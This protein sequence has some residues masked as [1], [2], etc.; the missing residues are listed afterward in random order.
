MSTSGLPIPPANNGALSSKSLLSVLACTNCAEIGGDLLRCSRCKRVC[1]CSKECQLKHWPDHKTWCSRNSDG[2]NVLELF[3]KA[4]A[5]PTF[6]N[7]LQAC[8]VLHFDLLRFPRTDKPFLAQIDFGV[9]PVDFLDFVKIFTGHPLG[10]RTIKGM[11]QVNSFDPYLP[12]EAARLNFMKNETWRRGK[13][14]LPQDHAGWSIGIIQI[15]DGE[16]QTIVAPMIVGD[17][18]LEFVR[19]HKSL[20]Y[21]Y[22]DGTVL[23]EVPLNIVTCLE[24]LNSCIRDDPN[25]E[26]CL[27]TDMRSSDIKIIREANGRRALSDDLATLILRCKMAREHIYKPLIHWTVVDYPRPRTIPEVGPQAS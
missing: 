19:T 22:P 2:S 6:S 10:N 12:A 8:F 23:R 13:A 16:K 27:R 14:S 7:M 20:K 18:A 11:V 9:E 4:M 21:N 1:Y 25:N 24:F 3:S 17:I 5:C 15:K 26:M